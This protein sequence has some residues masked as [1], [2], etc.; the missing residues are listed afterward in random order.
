MIAC[1]L[2]LN[3]FI[4]IYSIVT[5]ASRF[6]HGMRRGDLERQATEMLRRGSGKY[7]TDDKLIDEVQRRT[8]LARTWLWAK[9][10]FIKRLQ[11]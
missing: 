5:M 4:L 9:L 8:G 3:L 11:S 1:F 10:D 7:L 2:T 6:E